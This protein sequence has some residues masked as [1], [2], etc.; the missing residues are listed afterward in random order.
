MPRRHSAK[1]SR[2]HS[3]KK[4]RRRSKKSS[5]RRYRA[6]EEESIAEIREAIEGFTL[7]SKKNEFNPFEKVIYIPEIR[8]AIEG[9]T[10]VCKENEI[11]PKIRVA[12]QFEDG[13]ELEIPDA[14]NTEILLKYTFVHLSTQERIEGTKNIR[15]DISEWLKNNYNSLKDPDVPRIPSPLGTHRYINADIPVDLFVY[16]CMVQVRFYFVVFTHPRGHAA[17][18]PGGDRIPRRIWWVEKIGPCH[19]TGGG[20]AAAPGGGGLGTR[21]ATG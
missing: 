4:S 17:R 11:F 21:R 1:K 18:K 2:R 8:E 3:A 6:V 19:C 16:K 5:Q 15:R 9:F 10:L 12:T 20:G 7:E 13:G 14:N